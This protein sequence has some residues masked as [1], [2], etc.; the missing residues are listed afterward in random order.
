M[1]NTSISRVGASVSEPGL[2][3]LVHGCVY[4]S[5]LGFNPHV[6]PLN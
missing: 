3:L 5:W 4:S 6:R 1:V 2:E